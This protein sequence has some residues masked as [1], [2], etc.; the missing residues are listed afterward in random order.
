MGTTKRCHWCG[1]PLGDWVPKGYRWCQEQCE[2]ATVNFAFQS[3]GRRACKRDDKRVY[4]ER[5]RAVE[6]AETM[7][8]ANPQDPFSV[9][10]CPQH[11]GYHI[12]RPRARAR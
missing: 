4:S 6:A 8:S 5:F 10:Y 3:I 7:S 12:G 9:Y 1:D 11:G 2:E